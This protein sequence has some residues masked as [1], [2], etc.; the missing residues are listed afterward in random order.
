MGDKGEVLISILDELIGEELKRFKFSLESIEKK[1]S[2]QHI[3]R[4]KLEHA[5]VTDIVSLLIDHY[6]DHT[7]NVV[8]DALIHIKKRDLADQLQEKAETV[9]EEIHPKNRTTVCQESYK[10]EVK[11]KYGKTKDYNSLPGEW[12]DFDK[13]FTKLLILKRHPNLQ[14]RE[15][16][17]QSMGHLK[18]RE[19]YKNDE[20][21]CLQVEDVFASDE[22]GEIPSTIALQG[23]AGIGKTFTVNK[24]M[25][26]WASNNIFQGKFDYVFHFNFRELN[27]ISCNVSLIELISDRHSN[28]NLDEILARPEKIL[29][30]MDGFDEWKFPLDQDDSGLGKG[31]CSK[32]PVAI[33]VSR[34]L[35]RKI[36]S[37]STLL[38]TTRPASLGT[39]EE[40]V[41]LQR[42]AEILGFS[43]DEIQEYVFNYFPDKE[44]AAQALNYI[45][46]NESVLTLCF[47]PV[48]CWIVCEVIKDSIERG[49][50]ITRNLKT[51]TQVFV[52]FVRIL[53][54]YHGNKCPSD[55][56]HKL[57]SL[58]LAGVRKHQFLFQEEELEKLFSNHIQDASAFLDKILFKQNLSCRSAYHFL[59]LSIQE[60][61]A[62]MF[63]VSGMS[64]EERNN[65][66]CEAL[67]NSCFFNVVCFMFGL[68]NKNTQALIPDSIVLP[69]S[70]L[71]TQLENWMNKAMTSSS[72]DSYVLVL[73]HC[74]F[75][76]QDE[77]FVRKVMEY[78]Y[79][80]HLALIAGYLNKHDCTV[81]KY[82]IEQCGEVRSLDLLLCIL[83]EEEV[84]VLVEV[85]Q[86]C[87]CFSMEASNLTNTTVQNFCQML[88][89]HPDKNCLYLD[90]AL[91]K[92]QLNLFCQ[93]YWHRDLIADVN[94]IES[95][96]ING[97]LPEDFVLN[98]CALIIPKYNFEKIS[99]QNS[100]LSNNFL[101]GLCG[102]LETST[103]DLQS[104][105]LNDS[106]LTD[107]C[108]DSLSS[109][110]DEFSSSLV[111]LD[112][113]NNFFTDSSVASFIQ[114][115]LKYTSLEIFKLEGNQFSLEGKRNL[116][117]KEEMRRCGCR[118][119]VVDDGPVVSVRSSNEEE[120][121]ECKRYLSLYI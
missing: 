26:D 109:G 104:L 102:V 39:L 66:L 59:H 87:R 76:I 84:K 55:T 37:E 12:V 99:L 13:R 44:Q 32:Q 21:L 67:D 73:L 80:D 50:E 112:L 35:K 16:E 74:L 25:F 22:N 8:K 81:I 107:S 69:I 38:I 49:E 71:R 58:A 70:V 52:Q 97:D 54:K 114:I 23:P 30:L 118:L 19:T 120:H 41:T 106:H 43:A 92:K 4:G 17:L 89:T 33:T 20:D 119:S 72:Y 88:S 31:E 93:T 111:R 60:L 64:D 57:G 68:A 6:S 86:K 108:V 103:I 85:L 75:E 29:F 48:V 77:E 11:K 98:I 117:V 79:T 63:C 82:C 105:E 61:L 10:K 94:V 45:K 2:C 7:I 96:S 101:K 34:L 56:I 40:S 27:T 95:F 65:L 14:E 5:Q 83:G 1:Y 42:C 47:V 100:Q 78:Q 115:M 51:I 46:E 36:F 15:Y 18:L 53:L 116:D 110:L 91:K 90:I 3:P 28:L 62:A 121:Q 9:L 113:S 24:I